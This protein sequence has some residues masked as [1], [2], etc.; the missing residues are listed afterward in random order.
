MDGM[1]TFVFLLIAFS[2]GMRGKWVALTKSRKNVHLDVIY[3]C[4]DRKLRKI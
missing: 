4:V 3:I 1:N 2:L